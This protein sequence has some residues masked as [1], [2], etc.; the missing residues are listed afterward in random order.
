MDAG[1]WVAIVGGV[2]MIIAIVYSRT[3]K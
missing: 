2:L 1:S 3:A